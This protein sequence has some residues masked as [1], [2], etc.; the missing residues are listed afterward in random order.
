M[1]SRV[2][3]ERN[4][5]SRWGKPSSST[6]APG[7]SGNIG[8]ELAA[9]AEPDGYTLLMSSACI[10]I[11][12]SLYTRMPYDAKT[13]FAPISLVAE[14]HILMVV[15]QNFPAKTVN[16]FFA[17]ARNTPGQI[18]FGSFGNGTTGHLGM[19]MLQAH[20]GIT[21]TRVPFESAA[22]AALATIGGQIQGM[23]DNA[24]TVLNHIKAGPLRAIA[25]RRPRQIAQ[26]PDVP[27]FHEAG[28]KGFEASNW[29][30]LVWPGCAGQDPAPHHRAA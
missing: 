7:A 25:C 13:A 26:L 8:A 11:N 1:Y 19:E 23:V 20:A 27:T 22:D 15:G 17:Q 18:N 16:E 30:G 29:F 4:C 2:R 24:P 28:P 3:W 6:T 14:M 10:L 12:E 5:G 21:L 9:K